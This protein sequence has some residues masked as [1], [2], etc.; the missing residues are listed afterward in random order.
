MGIASTVAALQALHA[1]IS[2]VT[3][4]PTARPEDVK[5]ASLPC[6]IVR[7]G[8]ATVSADARRLA[9]SQRA[10]EGV[11]L[12]TAPNQGRGISEGLAR[13]HA[14]MDAFAAFYAGRIEGSTDLSTGGV[15]VGYRDSGEPSALL[16]YGASDYEGFTFTVDVW[17]G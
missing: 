14:L 13:S 5:P 3:S 1:T 17:E 2:G 12:V 9:G 11:V 10:Y 4:A 7:P 8:V 16:G 6:V 15:I